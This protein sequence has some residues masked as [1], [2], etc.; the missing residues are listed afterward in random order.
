MKFGKNHEFPLPQI[1]PE[2]VVTQPLELKLNERYKYK[3]L[4]TE[5]VDGPMLCGGI[6]PKANATTLYSGKV[7]IDGESFRE[8][9]RYLSQR[10][11]KNNVVVNVETQNL[12]WFRTARAI[13]S[14]C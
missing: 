11:P 7:W 6:E 8:V 5:Q 14:T 12:R 2:K 9:R 1:E 13:S 4:G 3:L 10:G